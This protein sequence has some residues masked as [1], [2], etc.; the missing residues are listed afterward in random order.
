MNIELSLIIPAYNEELRI[1]RTIISYVTRIKEHFKEFEILVVLNGCIDNTLQ[2]VQELQKKYPENLK[3]KNYEEAIGKGGA[4]IEGLK[5][6]QG[7]C[8]GFVDADDAFEVQEIINLIKLLDLNDCVIASKWKNQSF[9]DVTEPFTRKFFSRGWNMLVKVLLGLNFKD[10][11]AGAKFLNKNVKE[12][13]GND[14]IC[15]QFAFDAEFLL[16]IKEKNFAIKE[17]YIPS[18]HIAGSTFKLKHSFQMFTDL[19]KVWR[20]KL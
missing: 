9:F 16:K 10:T 6:C 17:V 18:K 8:I 2:V 12:A 15:K 20:S 11:Q 1:E 3:Y 5:H 13:I 7:G 4:I 14:F 19:L